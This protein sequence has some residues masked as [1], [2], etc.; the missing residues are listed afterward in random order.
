M[1]EQRRALTIDAALGG[2]YDRIGF[3]LAQ[4]GLEDASGAR[5]FYL[6]MLKDGKFEEVA[7]D[8][9]VSAQ[10]LAEEF[11]PVFRV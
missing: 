6:E 5:R 4:V 8:F 3:Y 11:K 9:K 7:R 10:A 2:A 1:N